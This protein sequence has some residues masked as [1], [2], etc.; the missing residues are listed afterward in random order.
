MTPCWM[1][2]P[3]IGSKVIELLSVVSAEINRL[4]K[5]KYTHPP[6]YPNGNKKSIK[7][8]W[9]LGLTYIPIKKLISLLNMSKT[10]N[11]LEYHHIAFNTAL[12]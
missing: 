12:R 6:D 10:Q 8:Y 7:I 5:A 4:T 3:Y 1:P 9:N 11:N 2:A